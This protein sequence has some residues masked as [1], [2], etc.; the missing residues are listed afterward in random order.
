M[1]INL[2][3]ETIVIKGESFSV[4]FT[5]KI[6]TPVFDMSKQA[7]KSFGMSK[8]G[9]KKWKKEMKKLWKNG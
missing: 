1:N 3:L 8:K 9:L 5:Y 7:R 4:P 2:D 6:G